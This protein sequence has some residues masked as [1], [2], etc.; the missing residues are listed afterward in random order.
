MSTGIMDFVRPAKTLDGAVYDTLNDLESALKAL[1]A[2]G[3]AYEWTLKPGCGPTSVLYERITPN[4]GVETG[5]V[6]V[7]ELA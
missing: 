3:G 7:R 1:H 6:F 2:R 5:L 4:G